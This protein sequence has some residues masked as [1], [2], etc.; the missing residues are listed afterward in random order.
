MNQ[1]ARKLVAKAEQALQNLTRAP[2]LRLAPQAEPLPLKDIRTPLRLF[3]AADFA[4]L[5]AGLILSWLAAALINHLYFHRLLAD[6]F[7]V[8]ALPRLANFAVI[9][10]GVLL[11]LGHKGHYRTRLPFW[12]EIQ[13]IAGAVFF[14]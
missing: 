1:P 3:M 9:A 2:E 8:D 10:S 13:Q 4:G 7:T 11:W 5:V 14:C 6:M 12:S